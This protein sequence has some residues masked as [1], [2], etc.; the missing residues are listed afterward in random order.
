MNLTRKQFN[1][2]GVI[3]FILMVACDKGYRHMLH[4]NIDLTGSF[5]PAQVAAMQCSYVLMP[6]VIGIYIYWGYRLRK[7]HQSTPKTILGDKSY[8]QASR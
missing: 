3:L 2:L 7:K 5:S 1:W 4:T 6:V 8:P